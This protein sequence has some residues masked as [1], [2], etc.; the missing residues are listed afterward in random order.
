MLLAGLLN[1]LAQM[2]LDKECGSRYLPDLDHAVEVV[3]AID[4][5]FLAQMREFSLD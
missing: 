1:N 3:D 5:H 2:V 4:G